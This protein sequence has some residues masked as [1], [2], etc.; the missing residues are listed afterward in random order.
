MNLEEYNKIQSKIF[1]KYKIECS[2]VNDSVEFF[3][4]CSLLSQHRDEELGYSSIKHMIMRI[5]EVGR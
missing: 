1:Q 4:I 2:V 3:K 5:K